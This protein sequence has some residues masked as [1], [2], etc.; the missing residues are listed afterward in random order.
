MRKPSKN[1]TNGISLSNVARCA[2]SAR[3]WVSWMLA[4]LVIAKPVA[5]HAI[6][7]EWSPKIDSDC[8]AKARAVTWKTHGS[9]SP[10][11]LYMLGIISRRPW[12]AV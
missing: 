6:T 8:A 2:T 5:R 4:A 3:S 12:L 1:A 9:I 10:A 7:S 11:I